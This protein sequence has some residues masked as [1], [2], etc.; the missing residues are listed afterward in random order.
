MLGALVRR[1]M[2]LFF[3]D[4]GMFLTSLI[5]PLILLLLYVSFLGNVY[6]DSFESAFAAFG[7]IDEGILSG[8]VG[9]QLMSSVLA[10][11]CVT[12][13]FCSNF[14]M[15]QDKVTGA[16]RDFAITPVGYFTRAMGYFLAS[17]FSS[18]LICVVAA[19]ACM[20][21]LAFIGWYLSIA[22]IVWILLDLVLLVGFGTALSG[23]VNS[24]LKSQGQ[25]S[26]VGTVVS[27]CYGFLCGAYMPISQFSP[28]LQKLLSFL[29]GTY[30]TALLR[31]HCMDGAFRAM[32]SDGA[33][34]EAVELMRETVDCRIFFFDHSV[35][36]PVML[37]ILAGTVALCTALYVGMHYRKGA[38]R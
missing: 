23:I 15:V 35:P 36:I 12:V 20:I 14:L 6:R 1:N 13:A 10:V 9:G 16:E 30:G 22:D 18:L 7:G 8:L 29:P 3:K 5:T 34:E 38:K 33:P 24:F 28:A 11:S 26:A 21:Y 4:K 2:R 17:F 32:A 25:I 19:V 37:G 31:N 27:S